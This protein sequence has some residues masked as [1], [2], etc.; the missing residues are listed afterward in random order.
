MND[1]QFPSKQWIIESLEEGYDLKITTIFSLSGGADIYAANYK[2]QTPNQSTFFVKIKQGNCHE[3]TLAIVE[4]LHGSGIKQVIPPLKTVH[5]QRSLHKG[6]YS[7]IVYPFIEGDNGFTQN[8]TSKQ[9]IA[10]GKALKQVHEIKLP[11]ELL[12]SVRQETFSSKWR[13]AVRALLV[14]IQ[15]NPSRNDAVTQKFLQWM[16]EHL[17]LVRRLLDRAEQLCITAKKQLETLVLCHSDLHAGNVLINKDGSIYLLDWD[18]LIMAPKE[19]DLMFI[20]GGVANVWN[21]KQ[22]EEVFYQGYGREEIN[23]P[24]LAYYRHERI[25]QDIAEYGRALFLASP[26]Q[27][28]NRSEMYKHFVDLFVPNGVIDIAVKT[29]EAI[30]A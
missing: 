18:E 13:D 10:L 6:N 11:S 19:R 3:Q 5:R 16:K 14:K 7:F 2:V 21:D 28:L 17:A 24:M 1:S 22:E 26:D 20:G 12:Q 30:Q 9:W 23:I 4:H 8:L 29:D 25:V 15:E 27:F